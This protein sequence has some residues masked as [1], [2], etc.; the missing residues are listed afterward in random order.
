[1][2]FTKRLNGTY[3]TDIKITVSINV[4]D[5]KKVAANAYAMEGSINKAAIESFLQD[6]VNLGIYTYSSNY[7]DADVSEEIM[8]K[9][10]K[11]I[12]IIK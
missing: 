2:K 12:Q 8:K 11:K 6:F 9:I 10:K 4:D 5:F 1:M 7:G 3:M